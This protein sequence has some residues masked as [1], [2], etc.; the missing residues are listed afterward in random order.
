MGGVI[1]D[2]TIDIHFQYAEEPTDQFL[3]TLV[4]ALI[5]HSL[6]RELPEPEGR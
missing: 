4:P 2:K 1:S 6:C 5:F 3:P